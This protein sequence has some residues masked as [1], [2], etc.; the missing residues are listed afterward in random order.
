MYHLLFALNFDY[1]NQTEYHQLWLLYHL[2][3]NDQ[4]AVGVQAQFLHGLGNSVV[5]GVG[6]AGGV[7]LAVDVDGTNLKVGVGSGTGL[8]AGGAG[9][10][11]G[12]GG[13]VPA[14]GGQGQGHGD[15]HDHCKQF[16]HG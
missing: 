14:A 7:V 2:V 1:Y 8:G 4:L 12:G 10:A 11:A 5:V 16:L 6:I 15:G 13:A 3:H 9:G